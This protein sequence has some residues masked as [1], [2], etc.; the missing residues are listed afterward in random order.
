MKIRRIALA[1]VVSDDTHCSNDCPGMSN[2]AQRCKFFG[3]ALT[4]D[5]RRKVHGNH[6]LEQCQSADT[7]NITVRVALH[8]RSGARVPFGSS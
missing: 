3:Q 7:K 4:W 5:P 2:D 1:I 6:R 8:P